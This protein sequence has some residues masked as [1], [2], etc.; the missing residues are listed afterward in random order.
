MDPGSDVEYTC[1]RGTSWPATGFRVLLDAT[2]EKNGCVYKGSRSAK[3]CI[4]ACA[5]TVSDLQGVDYDDV[6]ATKKMG[7][8]KVLQSADGG[9]S[10]IDSALTVSSTTQAFQ[11]KLYSTTTTTAAVTPNGMLSLGSILSWSFPYPSSP[12]PKKPLLGDA[13]K[14]IPYR[15]TIYPFWSDLVT[16]TNGVAFATVGD[17]VGSRRFLVTWD[18]AY[19]YNYASSHLFISVVFYEAETYVDVV[20]GPFENGNVPTTVYDPALPA[21]PAQPP[22]TIAVQNIEGNEATQ[23]SFF[24]VGGLT[25]YAKKAIRFSRVAPTCPL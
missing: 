23:S 1:Q 4:A 12:L 22:V 5:Y 13:D 24:N 16:R 3:V 17:T 15:D 10:I 18:D 7:V 25:A 20:Y 9:K 2:A 8:Q 11:I 19:V 21:G 14:D 6:N